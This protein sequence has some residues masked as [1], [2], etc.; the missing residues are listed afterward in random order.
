[1]DFDLPETTEA[2]GG[3]R[4][5]QFSIFTRNKVGAMLDIVRMLNDHHVEVLA[6][7]VEVSADAALVRV[8]VSDPDTIEGIFH[9]HQIPYSV[10]PLVV[11]E[12]NGASELG[13]LLAALLAAEVNIFG[14]YALLTQPRGRPAL[15]LHVE[16]NECAISVLKNGGFTVLSQS[17][18]S[19]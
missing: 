4:V 6:T 19:R 8:V 18:I 3:A 17:D 7:N 5:N 11:V 14:S 1:M 13:S 16:D 2:L 9:L 15:A 12:L 10:S